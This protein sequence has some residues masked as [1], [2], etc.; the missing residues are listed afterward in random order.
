MRWLLLFIPLVVLTAIGGFALLLQPRTEGASPLTGVVQGD[1][2]PY[3]RPQFTPEASVCQGVL[4][5]P[6]PGAPRTFPDIYTQRTEAAGIAIVA[7]AEVSPEAI[8]IAR[9]TIETI[10]ANN[11]LEDA[12]AVEGTYVVLAAAGENVLELPEFACLD[13]GAG[14]GIFDNVCGVADHADY[15]VATV[16]ELDLLGDR[17]GPC[18]GLNILYHEVGHLVQNFAIGPQDY[19]DVRILYQ[20][21]LSAGK[22]TGQ[23]AATNPHEYFTEATQSYFFEG[24]EGDREWLR[25]YDPGIFE[26]L[27]R[28]YN[29]R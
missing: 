18:G 10:F 20:E 21:A 16:N 27:D 1:A 25:A 17:R 4:H 12:L 5:R 14:S 9:D 22:Y 23:Y 13:G 19:L 29:G 11:D 15:P 8:E 2:S 6:D 7:P 28:V 26:L 3:A 24:D